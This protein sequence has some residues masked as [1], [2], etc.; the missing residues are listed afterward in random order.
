MLCLLNSLKLEQVDV[1]VLP[2]QQDK[3][4]V[5]SCTL[6]KVDEYCIGLALGSF[7]KLD[8]VLDGLCYCYAVVPADCSWV[9]SQTPR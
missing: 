5:P 6:S 7:S 9:W 1:M 4:G 3:L 2:F 8:L